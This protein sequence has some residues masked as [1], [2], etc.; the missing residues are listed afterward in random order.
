MSFLSR[1]ECSDDLC[2]QCGPG[3]PR[4]AEDSGPAVY[5]APLLADL[6]HVRELTLG[7]SSSGNADANSQYYW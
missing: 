7:S 3:S 2:V 5:E 6:G 1:N 4:S